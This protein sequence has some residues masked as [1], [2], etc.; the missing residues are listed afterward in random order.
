M[1][2][3]VEVDAVLVPARNRRDPR[4]HHLEHF[5]LDQAPLTQI[6]HRSSKPRT[7]PKLALRFWRQQQTTIRRLIAAV[8]N[9]EFL[10]VHRWKV[11]RTRRIVAHGG[12]GGRLVRFAIRVNN[13]LLRESGT[14]YYSRRSI[15]L[16]HE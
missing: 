12:C 8:K 14:S 4:H 15:H 13:D 5:V 3:P 2:Q 1:P 16:R 10:T 7:H 6:R 11:E 9:C